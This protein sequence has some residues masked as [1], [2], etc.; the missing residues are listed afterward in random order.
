MLHDIEM[1]EVNMRQTRITMKL[2]VTT[3]AATALL[4]LASTASAGPAGYCICEAE[5]CAVV[6][7]CYSAASFTSDATLG[8]TALASILTCNSA[9]GTCQATCAVVLLSPMP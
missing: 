1:V 9:F 7:A 8:A 4:L 3:N 5:C 2:S 6:A